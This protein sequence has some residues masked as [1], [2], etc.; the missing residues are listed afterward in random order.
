MNFCR[1]NPRVTPPPHN[2][3]PFPGAPGTPRAHTRTFPFEAAQ[4]TA[5]NAARPAM[6]AEP[7]HESK[8]AN[9]ERAA[10]SAARASARA[11]RAG[12]GRH[13]RAASQLPRVPLRPSRPAASEHAGAR[14]SSCSQ[15]LLPAGTALCGWAHALLYLFTT[16]GGH[17]HP[18][19]FKCLQVAAAWHWPR[20]QLS[21]ASGAAAQPLLQQPR[22][23]LPRM[24]TPATQDTAAA[25][26]HSATSRCQSKPAS[27]ISLGG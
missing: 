13:A 7:R 5:A 9:H 11:R 17:I 20:C 14:A 15:Q 3:N 6:M 24:G 25:R 10:A 26:C 1:R 21:A 12:A 16:A 22:R 27:L 18:C 8:P 19:R 4:L 23:A 2:G